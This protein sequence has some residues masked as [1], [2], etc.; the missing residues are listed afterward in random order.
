MKFNDYGIWGQDTELEK[1]QT[2]NQSPWAPVLLGG[3]TLVFTI[4]RKNS[5]TPQSAPAL[6]VSDSIYFFPLF[7]TEEPSSAK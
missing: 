6:T 1:P 3:P 4:R 7:G 2:S 5:E